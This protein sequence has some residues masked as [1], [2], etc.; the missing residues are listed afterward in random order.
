MILV[1]FFEH[2]KSSLKIAHFHKHVGLPN[3]YLN[4]RGCTL[5][6][7]NCFV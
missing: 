6:F 3:N 5:E 7:C 4:F 1:Y 2:V